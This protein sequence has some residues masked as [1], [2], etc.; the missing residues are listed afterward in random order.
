M[1][2][3]IIDTRRIECQRDNPGQPDS[4][5]RCQPFSVVHTPQGMGTDEGASL[6]LAFECQT[7][8]LP[9]RKPAHTDK[10][11]RFVED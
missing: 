6:P 9:V 3:S 5:V 10:P 4:Q 2:V 1:E 11:L 7:P 8:R